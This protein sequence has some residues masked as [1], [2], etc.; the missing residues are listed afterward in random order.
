MRLIGY[1]MSNDQF[2]RTEAVIP[3]KAEKLAELLQITFDT[4]LENRYVDDD[5][6]TVFD[7]NVMTIIIAR[8]IIFFIS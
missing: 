4:I 7:G 3:E 1:Y 5:M 8:I 2:M 6:R